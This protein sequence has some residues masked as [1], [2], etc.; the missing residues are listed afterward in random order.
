M[1]IAYRVRHRI[2]GRLR[3]KISPARQITEAHALCATLAG[4]LEV[5]SNAACASI[6]L[7]YDP[8]RTSCTA[9][10]E[11]LQADTPAVAAEHKPRSPPVPARCPSTNPAS[12]GS[13]AAFWS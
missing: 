10:L 4:V 1:S 5:R 8:A 2:P 7:H 11:T 6:I 13:C 9:L 3:L 12:A